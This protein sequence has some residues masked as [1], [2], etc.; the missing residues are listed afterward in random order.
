MKTTS[1]Q[2]E[3]TTNVTTTTLLTVQCNVSSRETTCK[4]LTS[5]TFRCLTSFNTHAKRLI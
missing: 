5:K 3:K 1:N 2:A 4:T